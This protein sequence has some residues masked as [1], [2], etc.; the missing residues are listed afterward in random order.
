MAGFIQIGDVIMLSQLAWKIGC[1]F[2]SGRAGA[3]AEFQEVE[4]EL[5]GLTT[6]LT[7]LSEA[8]DNDDGLLSRADEKTQLGIEK[9]IVSCKQSLQDLES[10]VNQYQ[11]IK[12][13]EGQG[14][15]MT[16]R[17]WKQL[18]VKNYKK[19]KWTTE[20]GDIQALR[21]MLHMH[22]ASISLTMQALQ[23][24]S[25]SRLE[26]TIEPMAEKIDDVHNLV[27]GDLNT[28]IDD[29]HS[30]MM[31]VATRSYASS[32]YDSSPRLTA[33]NVG[34][35]SQHPGSPFLLDAPGPQRNSYELLVTQPFTTSPQLMPQERNL[36]MIWPRPDSSTIPPMI[37]NS[38]LPRDIPL[39]IEDIARG[40][41]SSL[42]SYQSHT[43]LASSS[44]FSPQRT[45]E[46]AGSEASWGS[47]FSCRHSENG[48]DG[49]RISHSARKDSDPGLMVTNLEEPLTKTTSSVKHIPLPLSPTHS[50]GFSAMDQSSH[51]R[52]S[53]YSLPL[54][55]MS[56]T[57]LPPP[58][59]SIDPEV[60]A[61]AYVV[62]QNPAID[63]LSAI[64]TGQRP[65]DDEHHAF[66]SAIFKNAATLCEVKGTCVEYAVF[67]NEEGDFK[68]VQAAA[69]CHIYLIRRKEPLS[70]GGVR[71]FT[72]IWALSENRSVRIQQKL[73]DGIE[74]IP[75]TVWGSKE[76]VSIRTESQ[77]R[78]HDTTYDAKLLDTAKTTWI[79]YVFEDVY[80]S[81]IF[82]SALMDKPLL[83]SVK[84]TK[85][86]RIHEG[87]TG[88][89]QF[90]EQMCALENLRIWQDSSTGGA[91]AM[92][93]YTAN[94]RD[95]YMSFYLNSHRDPIRIK[96]ESDRWIRIKG[97]RTV[98][99][100]KA[101]PTPR[102][103]SG[104]QGPKSPTM[105]TKIEKAIT[106]ARI[107]FTTTHD[108]RL[109]LEKYEELRENSSFAGHV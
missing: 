62:S 45:P 24:K 108:R 56:P 93:H 96:E 69:D 84:T 82:Q 25:L 86:M 17:A 88:P 1:A 68:M 12:K 48:H 6:S 83:L 90:Q 74:I 41:V 109:F 44:R 92:I 5:T 31:S 98:E 27:L 36:E 50:N 80:A 57:F 77:L 59:I 106:G 65:S 33:A 2:T 22:V 52:P 89:L 39:R 37:R 21:N 47:P 55:P 40:R 67:D 101:P 18:L 66:E 87:I 19:I 4:N 79:N 28:K 8:L 95:G 85:T 107:E 72:S 58:A 10:F 99:N 23:S 70:S 26:Q 32:A 61:K 34:T 51:R 7:L 20:D 63:H 11:D 73:A 103:D 54:T 35:I 78:F 75:Y 9:I 71:F 81:T 16:E 94:F 49:S 43:S 29:M 14:A 42:D 105:K 76:K 30:F 91:L 3:P 13:T 104:L 38:T 53:D 46:L 100:K 60:E 64:Y 97:I 102:R 15:K